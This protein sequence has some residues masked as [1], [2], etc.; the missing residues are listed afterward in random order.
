MPTIESARHEVPPASA[1]SSTSSAVRAEVAEPVGERSTSPSAKIATVRWCRGADL[2][3]EDGPV[4][5]RQPLVDRMARD[6]GAVKL[7]LD[8]AA[9]GDQLSQL[10]GHD[11]QAPAPGRRERVDRTAVGDVDVGA[12]GRHAARDHVCGNVAKRHALD[13]A[14][15]G[16]DA[17]DHAPGWHVDRDLAFAVVGRRHPPRF[18]RP[19]AERDRPVSA[20]GRVAILVPEQNAK[21]GTAIVG[22]HEEA[23]VH[24]GVPAGLV[25]QQPA[26]AV[27]FLAARRVLAPVTD[28]VT[29]DLEHPEIDDPKRLA[30]G[31]VIGRVDLDSR[32][33]AYAAA[34]WVG[35]AR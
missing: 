24:V 3:V 11:P 6:L 31:V 5:S 30:G 28:R 7:V 2:L 8:P 9:Q 12:G 25:T 19:R 14:C 21:V 18:D 34:R 20:G 16:T 29:R 17:R 4:D 23:A 32:S 35:L 13:G 26:H 33:L 27:D 22:R 15:S 10:I 1:P